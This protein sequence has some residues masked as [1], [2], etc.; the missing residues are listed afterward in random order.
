MTF[1][2]PLRAFAG[3]VRT[4]LAA[5]VLVVA[6]LADAAVCGTE[7]STSSV[8]MDA[9]AEQ[10]PDAVSHGS[11]DGTEQAPL[12]GQHCVHG[13]C[14]HVT[15][16]E[17][18]DGGDTLFASPTDGPTPLVVGPALQHIALGLDRPPKA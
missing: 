4:A 18:R 10:A 12:D 14:H 3:L 13:H 11:Q 8:T 15:A 16:C 2:S 6:P 7:Q 17:D 9:A 1:V 5:A